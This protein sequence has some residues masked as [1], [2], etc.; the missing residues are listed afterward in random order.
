MKFEK[1]KNCLA[2]K[3]KDKWYLFLLVGIFLIA[4]KIRLF[5]AGTEW[6]QAY[7]P[8]FHLRYTSYVVNNRLLPA[9]DPLSYFPPGRPVTYSPLLY[10]MTGYIYLLLGGLFDSLLELAKYSTAVYGAL[11]IIPAYLAGK[12]FSDWKAGV[13]AAA[14]M[15]TIPAAIRRTSAGFYST[16]PFVL[17]FS[18][19][20]IYFF[21]RSFKKRDWLSYS[22]TAVSL[23]LFSLSWNQGWYIA[24]LA[25][26]SVFFYYIVL[27]LTGKE[28]W[29]T[30][31]KEKNIMP[32]LKKR[33]KKAYYP[34]KKLLIPIV[35]IFIVAVAGSRL[36][37]MDPVGIITEYVNFVLNPADVQIVNVSVAELQTLDV[38]GGAWQE[39][40]AR[41][42]VALVFLFPSLILLLWKKRVLGSLFFVW[43]A[44][45]FFFVTR[46]IRFMLIFAPA[47][48]VAAGVALSEIYNRLKDLGKYS[49][50]IAF[51]FLASLLASLSIPVLGVA[52]ATL[53]TL[54]ML[55][56][57][58]DTDNN[59]PDISKAVL[60]CT[61]LLSVIIVISQG[62]Q[63]GA[64]QQVGEPISDDWQE[65]YNFLKH[66]TAEDAVVGS[67]WDPGHRIS[68]ISQRRNIADGYHCPDKHCEPGLNTRISDLGRT[69]ITDD[70]DRAAEILEKYRGEASEVYWIASQDLI[71]KY[72]WPQYFATGCEAGDPQC[73]LYS[74]AYIED[75]TGNRLIYQAGIYLEQQNDSWVPVIEGR[76]GRFMFERM[77]I[78]EAGEY[79]E[80]TFDHDNVIP[81]TIWVHPEFQFVTHIP[82]FQED[83][84]FSR[85]YFY[86]D[87]F[88]NFDL[89][90]S[91][92]YVKI[93]QLTN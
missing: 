56:L 64:Q 84:L 36:L 55:F 60:V 71:G 39:L 15:G 93:Y 33:V 72:Q 61:A 32:P 37:G 82:E 38:L 5:T 4:L 41:T 14:F 6:L 87:D 50:L 17:F 80:K 65:A 92:N 27:V 30:K 58:V 29:E 42:S 52:I 83:S 40:F 26:G 67:W 8:Y 10:Y 70:E 68:G 90:F 89:A 11:V 53:T 47:V 91:N 49:T 1:A 59:I 28:E 9:W 18:L 76:D 74:M 81:G 88:E 62:A 24:F 57:K 12:E 22:L 43:T 25:I 46:G 45:T 34:F 48:S 63:V 85:M 3:I 77:L 44:F 31:G 54:S 35:V 75:Y 51:L 86:E 78:Q 16:D 20:T 23:V 66:E 79:T 13:L 69:L 7:D 19:L 21:A 2:N 73:P